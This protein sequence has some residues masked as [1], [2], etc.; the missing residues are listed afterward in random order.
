MFVT[1]SHAMLL[2]IG[3]EGSVM[4]VILVVT[5]HMLDRQ[6]SDAGHLSGHTTHVGQAGE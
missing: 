6:V 2:D 4:L 5:L 1:C 3:V